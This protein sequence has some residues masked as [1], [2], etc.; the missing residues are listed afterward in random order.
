MKMYLSKIKYDKNIPIVPSGEKVKAGELG[1]ICMKWV[2]MRGIHN[3]FREVLY[4]KPNRPNVQ[5][6][7][8]RRNLMGLYAN[9]EF[10]YEAYK[11]GDFY[12]Y[13]TLTRTCFPQFVKDD[14]FWKSI[15][16]TRFMLIDL[17]SSHGEGEYYYYYSYTGKLPSEAEAEQE[18]A[19]GIMEKINSQSH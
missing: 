8:S 10:I 1:I 15:E 14:A 2:N 7:V 3:W 9:I 18:W 13:D 5:Y 4:Y 6:Q 19:K 17:L 16:E 12:A 11:K